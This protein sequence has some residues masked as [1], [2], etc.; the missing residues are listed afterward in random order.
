MAGVIYKQGIKIVTTYADQRQIVSQ[1]NIV[2]GQNLRVNCPN[3]GGKKT[4]SISK[5]DGKL[6]WN[7]FKAACVIGGRENVGRS[8]NEIRN[9][10]NGIQNKFERKSPDIPT[11]L[12]NPYSSNATIK[13]LKDNNSLHAFES[14]LVRIQYHP[15]ENRVL[16]FNQSEKGCVGRSILK[17]IKPK[18][19]AYGDTSELFTVGNSEHGVLVEDAASA[20]SV[21]STGHYSGICLLGTH[22]NREQKRTIIE[23]YKTVIIA[24]DKDATRK[25]ILLLQQLRGAIKAHVKMLEA[26]LKQYKVKQ[27][28]EI[29]NNESKGG[30]VGRS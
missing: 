6:V 15:A 20:C 19:K 7:C 22:M 23:R 2:N 14:G 25:S 12:S 9:T 5:F 1:Y 8:R 4:L 21:A 24:L 16:F 10:L 11:V 13:Y 27:L 17:G 3:C 30:H 18:W 29:L 28:M 26:D